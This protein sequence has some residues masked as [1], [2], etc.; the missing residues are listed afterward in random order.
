[1]SVVGGYGGTAGAG[2]VVSGLGQAAKNKRRPRGGAL[3]EGSAEPQSSQLR[4][5]PTES[6]SMRKSNPPVWVALPLTVSSKA[7]A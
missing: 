3:S 6:W 1:M 5:R 4:L 2:W 7:W